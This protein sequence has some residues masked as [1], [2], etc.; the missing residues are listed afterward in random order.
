MF[1]FYGLLPLFKQ[2]SARLLS[3]GTDTICF[4]LMTLYAF[5]DTKTSYQGIPKKPPHMYF[6]FRTWD[7][8]AY[9][10][11]DENVDEV[12]C[13][14]FCVRKALQTLYTA[15]HIL[16]PFSTCRHLMVPPESRKQLVSY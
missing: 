12:G 1:I 16:I 3:S 4:N 11:T 5:S 10:V 15:R 8:E 13:K 9:D 14:E 2:I 7:F 6:V